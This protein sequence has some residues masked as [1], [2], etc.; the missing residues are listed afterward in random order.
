MRMFVLSLVLA[1]TAVSLSAC[2]TLSPEQQRAADEDQCRRYGFKYGTDGFAGCLQRI[3]LYR[4]AQYRYDSD[5]LMMGMAFELDPSYYG[6]PYW[7][8]YRW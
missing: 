7:R 8:H 2:Q 6:R 5:R 3:D 4:R 1:A